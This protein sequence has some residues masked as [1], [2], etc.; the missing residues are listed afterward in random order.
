[1]ATEPESAA[2]TSRTSRFTRPAAVY[3]YLLGAG[4]L[5]VTALFGGGSLLLDPTGAS[6]EM[7]VAWLDGTPFTDYS[8]P[9]LI[10]FSVL[11]VGSLVVM[12][13]V[14]R[15]WRGA[16]TASLGLGVA[17]VGWIVVQVLLI[18]MG[19]VFHLLYGTLGVV[20][21]ALALTDGF[22]SDVAR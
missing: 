11:G 10:L 16:W 22:R 12:V 14:H 1:M 7:P 17:L 13:G 8:L 4:V 3:G 5:G 19:H 21:V 2:G 6:M 20:L 15:R 9:G 18:R